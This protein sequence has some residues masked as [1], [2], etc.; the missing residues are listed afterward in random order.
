[1]RALVSS[2]LIS[3]IDPEQKSWPLL[4]AGARAFAWHPA[5]HSRFP[6]AEPAQPHRRRVVPT[7]AW[8]Q[9]S[10]NFY[11]KNFL[12]KNPF[13]PEAYQMRA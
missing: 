4:A 1:M 5:H 9:S 2:A 10:L 3:G 7:D 11:F 12:A 13:S 6:Q 8:R